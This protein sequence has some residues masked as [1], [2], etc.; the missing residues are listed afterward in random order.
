MDVERIER[1]LREGPAGEPMYVPG[2]FRGTSRPGLSLLVVSGAVGAA[3]V[4]GLAVGIS[5]QVIRGPD[6][7]GRQVDIVALHTEL[8]GRWESDVIGREQWIA[9]LVSRGHQLNDI[10]AYFQH[11]PLE[12]SVQ[13]ILVFRS[14][15]LSIMSVADGT[16]EQALTAGEFDLLSDGRLTWQDEGGTALSDPCVLTAKPEIETDRLGFSDVVTAG[17]TADESIAMGAFFD[18]VGYRRLP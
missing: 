11:D 4:I 13:Y 16:L 9:A 14:S 15:Q 5:L 1:A 6:G 10:E 3:L 12:E 17:C 2:R 7:V 18:I 8:Q